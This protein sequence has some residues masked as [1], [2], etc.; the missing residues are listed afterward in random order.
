[1]IIHQAQILRIKYTS[2]SSSF[3]LT[4]KIYL[5]LNKQKTN[6]LKLKISILVFLFFAITLFGQTN[7]I[8]D[9]LK[10]EL[11]KKQKD[12]VKAQVLNDLAYY[13]LYQD[14]DTSLIYGKRAEKFASQIKYAK[15]KAKANLYIGNAFLFTNRYDSARVYYKKAFQIFDSEGLN[16]SAIYSSMGMLYKNEGDYKKAIETYFEGLTYD[17]ETSN[18]YG[19]F[20][21][22]LN[23]ANVYYII[24]DYHKSI[25]YQKEA[26]L[27]AKITDNE[28]IKFGLGTIL[29]NIGGNYVKINEFDEANDYFN[30]S[31]RI[32]LKNENKKEIARNYHN[33]GSLYEKQSHLSKSLAFL[34]K[35]LKIREM[36]RDEDELAETH[37]SLGTTYGKLLQKSPS[38]Y[39]YKKALDIANKINNTSLISEIYLAMSNVFILQNKP[40][41]ALASYKNHTLYRDSILQTENL[42]NINE[43]E[44]KYETEKK[45]KEI[46]QQQLQLEK[47]EKELQ[48][49]KTQTNY[50][51]GIAVFLLVASI[52]TWFLFQQRQK[53]KNQEI[54]TL[55]REHQ[56][57]T[58]ESLMEGE[59]KERF[60]IAKELHDGVN[61]DLSAIKYKLSTLLEMNNAVI[62]EAITMID[63]SCSQVR[64]ISH[65]LV[66]PSL[67]NF[68]LLEAVEEYCEKSDASHSQK[69]IFQRLGNAV[70]MS[71]KEEINIFRIIQELVTNSIKHAVATEINVQISCRNKIMQITVEDNGKGFDTDNIKGNGIGLKN[72]QSRI[73]YLHANLDVLS[74]KKGTSTTIEIDKNKNDNN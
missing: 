28:N 59:E 3:I 37:M 20:I 13:Y 71:K 23:L 42:K 5:F 57:Q 46:I 56:V 49:K 70:N 43:I 19:K 4:H 30:K 12:T 29:N 41:Q 69:I 45:D 66:P 60:R 54:L 33:L 53:R 16:K 40:K 58:L 31:L 10:L 64:A 26:V 27:V 61:G 6:T 34:N 47:T 18:D 44:T 39:H 67:E 50:L 22:L 38:Q 36:L 9:S 55:K 51:I 7:E 32:N 65:N 15:V 52:L 63:K 74:N 35:S 24:E 2:S 11:S 68:N 62:K 21:K 72:I 25:S 1:M 17:E 73:D 8:I 48:K 14:I